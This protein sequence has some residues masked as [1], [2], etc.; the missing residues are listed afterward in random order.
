MILFLSSMLYSNAC[1]LLFEGNKILVS[2]TVVLRQWERSKQKFGFINSF[3]KA[4]FLF[5]FR[6]YLYFHV[7]VIVL[8]IRGQW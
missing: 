7:I 1:I 6:R 3:D 2:K 8:V 5:S 4:K